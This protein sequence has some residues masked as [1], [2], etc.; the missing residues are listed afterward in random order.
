[1]KKMVANALWL[2]DATRGFVRANEPAQAINFAS[3]AVELELQD[4]VVAAIL[5]GQDWPAVIQLEQETRSA[6]EQALAQSW[7]IEF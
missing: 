6:F 5:A 3:S 2:V 1:M 4:A 7:T